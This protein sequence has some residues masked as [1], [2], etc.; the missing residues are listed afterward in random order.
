M[1]YF[2]SDE[3]IKK[4]IAWQLQEEKEEREK[5]ARNLPVWQKNLSWE[6]LQRTKLFNRK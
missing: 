5:N 3:E 6:K 1:N 2:K 4:Q